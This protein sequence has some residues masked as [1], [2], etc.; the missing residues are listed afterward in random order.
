MIKS[1]TEG[2]D[3]VERRIRNLLA[4]HTVGAQAKVES[5]SATVNRKKGRVPL[6]RT[7]GD[8]VIA[9]RANA[10]KGRNILYLSDAEKTAAL[11]IWKEAINQMI[12]KKIASLDVLL[13]NAKKLAQFII[14][15]YIEHVNF[16]RGEQGPMRPVTT[17]WQL[18]KDREVGPGKGP[19][20]Y[21]GQIIKALKAASR[22]I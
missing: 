14:N 3:K 15:K 13:G 9:M 7:A 8:N 20:Q 2:I 6:P 16:N 5:T 21:T 18:Q 19:M 1:K 12:N 4:T 22:K 17:G 11:K 10:K